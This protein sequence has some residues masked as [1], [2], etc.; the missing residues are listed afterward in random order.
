MAQTSAKGKGEIVRDCPE[1]AGRLADCGVEEGTCFKEL[2]RYIRLNP[3]K[4]TP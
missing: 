1:L 4:V 3:L 2:V